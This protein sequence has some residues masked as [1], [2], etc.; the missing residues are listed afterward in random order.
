MN[1]GLSYC[2]EILLRKLNP[3]IIILKYLF[4]QGKRNT[5]IKTELIEIFSDKREEFFI[6]DELIRTKKYDEADN[7]GH[8]DD[9]VN[10][11][12]KDKNINFKS[13]ENKWKELFIIIINRIYLSIIISNNNKYIKINRKKK[14]QIGVEANQL[15]EK[16]V[17]KIHGHKL[18]HNL[19]QILR[20]IIHHILHHKMLLQFFSCKCEF[21]MYSNIVA[22]EIYRYFRK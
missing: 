3:L 20:L 1:W 18:Y 6:M 21:V 4:I 8:L 10:F 13:E 9:M 16:K 19:L 11:I 7:S 17:V 14:L 22:L 5:L 12:L 15:V 2:C